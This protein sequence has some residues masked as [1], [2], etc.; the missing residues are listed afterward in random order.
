VGEERAQAAKGHH[1]AQQ[2]EAQLLVRLTRA[3]ARGRLDAMPH[4]LPASLAVHSLLPPPCIVPC[5][6]KRENESDPLYAHRA[7]VS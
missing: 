2:D 4:R 1:Q 5:P 7:A 3:R 6:L